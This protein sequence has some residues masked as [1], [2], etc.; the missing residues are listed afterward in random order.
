MNVLADILDAVALDEDLVG[1]G[2]KEAGVLYKE[3]MIPGR[4]LESGSAGP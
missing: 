4:T 2:I 1:V 3:V